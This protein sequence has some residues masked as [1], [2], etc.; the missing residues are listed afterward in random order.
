VCV[1]VRA[2]TKLGWIVDCLSTRSPFLNSRDW[3]IGISI[4]IGGTEDNAREVYKQLGLD[5]LYANMNAGIPPKWV[6]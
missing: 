3:S 4:S 2:H 1:C 5:P 6:S